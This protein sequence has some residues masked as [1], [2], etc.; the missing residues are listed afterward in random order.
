M[1][2]SQTSGGVG[3]AI[4]TVLTELLQTLIDQEILTRV[5]VEATLERS[6]SAL[7]AKRSVISHSEALDLVGELLKRFESRS[8]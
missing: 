4:G 3:L 2:Y 5:E 8:A 1:A 7:A 6:I